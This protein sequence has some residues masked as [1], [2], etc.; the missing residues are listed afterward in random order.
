MPRMDGFA[1]AECLKEEF[2]QLPILA[3][4]GYVEADEIEGHNFSGFLEK[5]M[6][7]EDFQ[8]MIE[9]ALAREA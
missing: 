1:L 5:P 2:P 6:R 9:G 8:Q 4:S 3:L 7:I